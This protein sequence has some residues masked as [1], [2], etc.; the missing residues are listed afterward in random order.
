M[1]LRKGSMI[2]DQIFLTAVEVIIIS[3]TLLEKY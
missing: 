2:F 3:R 1:K